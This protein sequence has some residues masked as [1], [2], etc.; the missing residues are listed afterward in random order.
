MKVPSNI[1][2]VPKGT[3][4][5]FDM[6]TGIKIRGLGML[7]HVQVGYLYTVEII[8]AQYATRQIPLISWPRTRTAT[9]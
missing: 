1:C 9:L 7:R 3:R 5:Q 8:V 2:G 4:V 6:V